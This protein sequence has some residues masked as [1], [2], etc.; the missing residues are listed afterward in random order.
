MDNIPVL[1][2]DVKELSFVSNIDQFEIDSAEL[3]KDI[4]S[5]GPDSTDADFIQAFD[6]VKALTGYEDRIKQAQQD[7]MQRCGDLYNF[8]ERTD[9]VKASF[10]NI[11]IPL[12]R[13]YTDQ[14]ILNK[15]FV[16]Q[17]TVDRANGYVATLSEPLD[18][19]F[20]WPVFHCEPKNKRS[21][22]KF[23]EACQDAL[24][25]YMVVCDQFALNMT[26]RSKAFVRAA[27][28]HEYLFPDDAKIIQGMEA[29]LIANVVRGRISEAKQ[30]QE[31]AALAADS[32]VTAVAVAVVPDVVFETV[33]SVDFETGEVLEEVVVVDTVTLP[34]A[35]LIEVLE[36]VIMTM[37]DNGLDQ[38]SSYVRATSMM[39]KC[40]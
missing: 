34:R 8:I 16:I 2:A 6:N 29:S 39:E 15:K 1:H 26:L 33:E 9:A 25:A 28:G 17:T 7:V 12:K 36:G 3:I 22:D 13:L 21:M 23:A 5:L 30:A 32:K 10:A 35:E 38:T 19:D 18:H 40:K 27:T 20:D 11:R 4:P 24:D 14:K 31:A 37:L